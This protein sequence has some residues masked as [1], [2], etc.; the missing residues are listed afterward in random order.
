MAV[1]KLAGKNV[2][3][4]YLLDNSMKTFL[5]DDDA[6]A[7][8][9]CAHVGADMGIPMET[10]YCF[11]LHECKDGVTIEAPLNDSEPV[12]KI[13]DA[14]G[15]SESSKFVFTVKLFMASQR[16]EAHPV[17]TYLHFIQ[18]VYNIICGLY[19]VAA[20]GAVQLAALQ[21]LHKFG[22][23]NPDVHKVGFITNQ[24]IGFI[25]ASLL[26]VKAATAW[27]EE[28]FR[29]HARL[30]I[31]KDEAPREYLRKLAPMDFFGCAF[32]PVAQSF[33][34]KLPKQLLLGIGSGGVHMF[35]SESKDLLAKYSLTEIYR[36]GF[37]PR[38]SFYVNLKQGAT[39]GFRTMQG[40]QISELLTDYAMGL[41]KELGVGDAAGGDETK[42]ATEGGET[43]EDTEAAAATKMQ[44]M[45]R[46]YR[47][48]RDLEH[49]YAAVRVQAIY[50][51]YRE[52][53]KFDDMIAK[54][55]AELEAA[56]AEG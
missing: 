31:G 37:K 21:V 45:F 44:A 9:V 35:E 40:S 15:S 42:D 4:V 1:R 51:G 28:I 36:W 34:K 6:T 16:D 18:S 8:D 54:M 33:S 10:L 23:H 11:S 12:V 53:C 30:T 55:E 56:E 41:L 5:V 47:L 14:W 38:T 2:C 43:E 27:E 20:D 26:S 3:R 25:P 24:L 46:G 52:R 19:P 29:A 48:R 7:G 13:M 49:D 22:P 17:I 50:R 32:F 39:Y